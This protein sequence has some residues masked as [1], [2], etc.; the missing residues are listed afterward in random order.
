MDAKFRDWKRKENVYGEWMSRGVQGEGGWNRFRIICWPLCLSYSYPRFIRFSF[1]S[2]NSLFLPYPIFIF[3]TWLQWPS[4]TIP[5][6]SSFKHKV[7]D[8]SRWICSLC[9]AVYSLILWN[10]W[11]I[12]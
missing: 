6:K 8:E 3:Q 12:F 11:D 10:L 2:S 1:L 9:N 5:G 4:F 7:S